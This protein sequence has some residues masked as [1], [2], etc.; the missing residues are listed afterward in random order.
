VGKPNSYLS[1]EALKEQALS[2]LQS[3]QQL[4]QRVISYFK[5]D[6]IAYAAMTD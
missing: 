5:Q 3:I 4:P 6:D 2:K 1:L